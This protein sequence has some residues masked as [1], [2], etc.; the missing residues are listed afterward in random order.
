MDNDLDILAAAL[1]AARQPLALTGA[2]I[3][4][5]SGIP[6]F[7]SP[8]GLWEKFN[9][10]DYLT[11]DAFRRDPERPRS[12]EAARSVMSDL[13]LTCLMRPLLRGIPPWM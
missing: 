7:R 2:G 12:L 6:D 10:M 13:Y 3:S 9:P 4:V 5:E 11:I 1:C 8:G